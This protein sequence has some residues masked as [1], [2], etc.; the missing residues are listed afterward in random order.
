MFAVL[1]YVLKTRVDSSLVVHKEDLRVEESLRDNLRRDIAEL[2]NSEVEKQRWFPLVSMRPSNAKKLEYA[3]DSVP[4]EVTLDRLIVINKPPSMGTLYMNVELSVNASEQQSLDATIEAYRDGIAGSLQTDEQRH[5]LTRWVPNR[6][7]SSR[8]VIRKG[9]AKVQF[10]AAET[11]D[12]ELTPFTE[13]QLVSMYAEM[14]ETMPNSS[15]KVEA[16]PVAP[17]PA[18][19]KIP[20]K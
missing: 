2:R 5:T 9:V 1:N 11:W 10:S 8:S 6:E 16:A 7:P 13:T 17:A 15:F 14:D 4:S 20:K 12:F 18:A 19:N 3:L